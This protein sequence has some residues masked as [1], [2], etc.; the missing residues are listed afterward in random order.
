M[1]RSRFAAIKPCLLAAFGSASQSLTDKR[2]AIRSLFNRFIANRLRAVV[3]SELQ[4][5]GEVLS[6]LQL[7]KT[8]AADLGHL[9]Y[10]ERKPKRLGTEA[11]SV[12]APSFLEEPEA[13]CAPPAISRTAYAK[14]YNRSRLCGQAKAKVKCS[15]CGFFFPGPSSL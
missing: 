13:P 9:S 11:K 8:P 15:T 2:W 10:I 1:T 7:R 6:A 4:I 14:I 3:K 12:A 5:P